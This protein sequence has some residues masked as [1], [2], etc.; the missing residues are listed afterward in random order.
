MTMYKDLTGR[1]PSATNQ[2]ARGSVVVLIAAVIAY[3][4]AGNAAGKYEEQWT[5]TI[6]A[7]EI[8][9]GLRAGSEVKYLGT[10]VGAVDTI[11]NK[12]YGAS[13]KLDFPNTV[14]AKLDLRDDLAVNYTSSNGLGPIVLEIVDAGRG[15][16][17]P[18]NGS[19]YVSKEQSNQT[20]VSTLVRK[21]AKL[22]G[23][24]DTPAFNAV[25]KFVVDQSQTVADSGRVMFELARLTR[26]VQ[27]RPASED[28]KIAAD[29]S[30]GAADFLEPFVPGLVVNADIADFFG[31]PSNVDRSIGN[32]T[33]TGEVLFGGLG[34]L[35]SKNYPALNSLLDVGLDLATPVARSASGL[36]LTIDTLPELLERIDR[37]TPRIDDRVQLQV[38]AIIRT[39]PVF[40]QALAV[41]VP[42]SGVR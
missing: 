10:T 13:V 2:L 19:V 39:S 31:T 1:A 9:D 37:A 3:F 38:A 34:G 27:Q 36:A 16:G 35:L 11:D 23:A 32:L 22:V 17:I 6:E 42:L 8:G 40:Q 28:L 25:V 20:S 14:G 12:Q 26:D 5:V 24:L 7:E 18:K 15:V 4:I 29:L 33:D 30:S 41:A 21:I